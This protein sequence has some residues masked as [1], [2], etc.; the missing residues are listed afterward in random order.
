MKE[1]IKELMEMYQ[2][3]ITVFITSKDAAAIMGVSNG[4]LANRRYRKENSPP[5]FRVGSLVRYKLSDVVE[6]LE[7]E[8]V[9]GC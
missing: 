7:Y 6:W 9:P 4:A 2:Q 8:M 5:Y 3:E 1:R